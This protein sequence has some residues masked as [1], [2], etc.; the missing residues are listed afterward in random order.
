MTAQVVTKKNLVAQFVTEHKWLQ[1]LRPQGQWEAFKKK[2]TRWHRTTNTR[3]WR[4]YDWI[5]PVGPI[6]WKHPDINEYMFGA[7]SSSG[8]LVV[9]ISIHLS[10]CLRALLK[11]DIYKSSRVTCHLTELL[12]VL[13]HRLSWNTNCDETHDVMW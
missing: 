4:L 10:V 11:R 1:N 5:C 13:K 3:T 7:L 12:N 9:C 8:S 2:F 6:Q